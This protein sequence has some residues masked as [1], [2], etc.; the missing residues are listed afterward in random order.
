MHI[1]MVPEDPLKP[2]EDL[3]N[4]LHSYGQLTLLDQVWA[5]AKTYINQEEQAAK[6]IA[7]LYLLRAK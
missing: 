4:L 2:D 3:I 5:H 1:L 7:Q 6:D